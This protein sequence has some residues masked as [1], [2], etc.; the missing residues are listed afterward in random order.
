[1]LC[2]CNHIID[3]IFLGGQCCSQDRIF[4]EVQGISVIFNITNDV[5]FQSD[6]HKYC[7]LYRL[8]IDDNLQP[9]EIKK[10][11][12]AL[13]S[14][15]PLLRKHVTKN[16][17]TLVHCYAGIQRSATFIAGYLM[18]YYNMTPTQA[19]AFIRKR[20]HIAFSPSPNFLES[21]VLYYIYLKN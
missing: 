20:R 11:Y 15:V 13:V 14:Y 21:L 16:N 12:V 17:R 9:S 3:G 4:L 10:M 8:A 7:S 6:V 18:K 19:I 2:D 5:P 1:M